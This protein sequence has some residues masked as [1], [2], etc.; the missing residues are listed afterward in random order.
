MYNIR[1]L[2]SWEPTVYCVLPNNKYLSYNDTQQLTEIFSIYH[3]GYTIAFI[4]SSKESTSHAGCFHGPFVCV[5]S[6]SLRC[7]QNIRCKKILKNKSFDDASLQSNSK[8]RLCKC[9]K[10][11][12]LK[13]EIWFCQASKNHHGN[14]LWQS[15]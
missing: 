3:I 10:V 4:I 8:Q 7:T 11:I 1:L 15:L 5:I 14:E 2:L 12:Y 13:Y 9:F 6:W